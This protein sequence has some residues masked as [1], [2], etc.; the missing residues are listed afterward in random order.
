[1]TL[2]ISEAHGIDADAPR[3]VSVAILTL[4]RRIVPI[5]CAELPYARGLRAAALGCEAHE[6]LRRSR[7]TKRG[8]QRARGR[9]KAA[10][11]ERARLDRLRSALNRVAKRALGTDLLGGM[12]SIF[13]LLREVGA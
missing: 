6:F 10:R 13:Q 7:V 2:A 8:A 3:E 12:P 11:R 9:R 1:M 5:W 4:M